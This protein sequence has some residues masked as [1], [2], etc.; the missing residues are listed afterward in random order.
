MLVQ[1]VGASSSWSSLIVFEGS[2]ELRIS[3][4]HLN[5]TSLVPSSS[6]YIKEAD[7]GIHGNLKDRRVYINNIY[8]PQSVGIDLPLPHNS[9]LLVAGLTPHI[10]RVL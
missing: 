1:L 10:I 5:L 6:F 7:Y 4:F 2:L 9:I 8:T 3:R